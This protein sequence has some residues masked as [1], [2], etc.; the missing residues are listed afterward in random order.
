MTTDRD[1]I[2]GNCDGD[3]APGVRCCG[4]PDPLTYVDGKPCTPRD[5]ASEPID[6]QRRRLP[7]TDPLTP[8]RAIS[9]NTDVV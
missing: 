1:W 8:Y 4:D 3:T 6:E 2:C 7:L 9:G 5:L